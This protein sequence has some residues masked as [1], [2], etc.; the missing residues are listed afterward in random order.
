[1]DFTVDFHAAPSVEFVGGTLQGEL[2]Q[3][4]VQTIFMVF[5]ETR[6][7]NRKRL[8]KARSWQRGLPGSTRDKWSLAKGAKYPRYRR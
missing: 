4:G 6:R 3:F 1:M 8:M 5:L 2:I 7:I